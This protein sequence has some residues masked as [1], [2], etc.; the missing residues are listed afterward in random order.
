MPIAPVVLSERRVRHAA[1]LRLAQ[2]QVGLI[3][4][5]RIHREPTTTAAVGGVF[6]RQSPQ[7]CFSDGNGFWDKLF[8]SNKKEEKAQDSNQRQHRGNSDDFQ[9]GVGVEE[10]EEDVEGSRSVESETET[11]GRPLTKAEKHKRKIA[12]SQRLMR[13]L[14]RTVGVRYAVNKELEPLAKGA[15]FPTSAFPI[16]MKSLSGAQ[17]Q[18]GKLC[19]RAPVT[20]FFASAN[21]AASQPTVT[22]FHDAFVERF[23]S[24]DERATSQAASDDADVAAAPQ[25]VELSI[26]SSGLLPQF[27]G[28]MLEG[29]LRNGTPAGRHESTA[30]VTTQTS[31]IKQALG[32]DD[33]LVGFFYVCDRSGNVQLSGRCDE[34]KVELMLAAVEELIAAEEAALEKAA[35]ADTAAME[36]AEAE[37]KRVVDKKAVDSLK[38][39]AAKKLKRS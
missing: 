17:F 23:G 30:F 19:A 32:I 35:A 5:R 13:E 27:M 34:D 8:P 31:Q 39:K 15:K 22:K 10:V 16:V 29:F 36:E 24:L 4:R 3:A 18:V 14:E 28:G 26:A 2:R 12:R 25:A 6:R 38:A 37:R 33:I 11:S 21:N 7:R 1:M 9:R 20:V